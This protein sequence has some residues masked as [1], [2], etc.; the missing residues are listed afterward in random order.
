MTSVKIKRNKTNEIAKNT[1]NNSIR[2][3]L[4]I[5]SFVLLKHSLCL[6]VENV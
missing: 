3:I 4:T 5:I 1:D 2:K 6:N